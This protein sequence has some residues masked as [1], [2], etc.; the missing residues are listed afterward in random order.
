MLWILACELDGKGE[1]E[2]D[3]GGGEGGEGREGMVT[4]VGKS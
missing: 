3:S 1:G 4:R 2:G